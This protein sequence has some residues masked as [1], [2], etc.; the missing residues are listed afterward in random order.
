MQLQ[1]GPFLACGARG[2]LTGVALLE[3]KI[4]NGRWDLAGI[5]K[6]F[7]PRSAARQSNEALRDGSN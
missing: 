2:S 1:R 7:K 4:A 3:D 5:K 6:L